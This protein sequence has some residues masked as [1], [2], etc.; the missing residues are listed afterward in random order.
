M[1]R[2]EF[3]KLSLIRIKEAEILFNNRRY[4]GAYYLSGYSIECAL[5]A[6]IAKKT[7]KYDFP[8]KQKVIDSYTH[9][10]KKLIK[11]AGLEPELN[12][13][14][15]AN[16]IFASNWNTVQDWTEEYRYNPNINRLK[17]LNIYNAIIDNNDGVL[18]WLKRH[19]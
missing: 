10:L 12:R 5:K 8:E 3:K 14:M 16:T 11:V 9:D 17:A 1:N 7:K 2:R 15:R 19:W 4:H 18:L 13:E 6:C